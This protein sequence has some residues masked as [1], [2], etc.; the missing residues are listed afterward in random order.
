MFKQPHS[1][2][3]GK[4]S[5]ALYFTHR[6]KESL[7]GIFSRPLTI[8]EA[9]MGYGKTV[10]VRE[11]LRATPAR[12]LWVSV[13]N[14]AREDFW[15]NF[16]REILHHFPHYADLAESLLRLG[17][18][19]D[20][21]QLAAARELMLHLD[22]DRPAV[23]VIDDCHL[24]GDP[25]TQGFAALCELLAQDEIDNL[26]MVLVNREAY[27]G[28]HELPHLRGLAGFATKD[29]FTLT[30]GE[31]Q[32]YYARC[33]EHLP[34][35]H[36]RRL[37]QSTGGWISALYLH[38]LRYSKHGVLARP[39]GIAAL[40]EKEIYAP[41]PVAVK[42]LLFA[43]CP[44]DAFTTEQADFLY[45][46]STAGH[47]ETLRGKN[48]F[49]TFDA[50]SGTFVMHSI[51]KQ[52]LAELFARLPEERR[53]AIHRACG[54][55]FIQ[56]G[57]IASGME[58]YYAAKD[59]EK[60]L[61]ALESDMSRNLVTEKAAF[62]TEMFKACPEEI[63]ERHLPAAFKY[64]IAAFSA[65]DFPAFGAQ[66][67]W[68]AKRCAALPEPQPSVLNDARMWRG[69][70]EFLYSLAAYNDIKAMSAHHRR[71]NALLGRPTRL[72]GARGSPWTLGSPSVL[73]MFYRQS[74]KLKD[75]RK[76]MKECLPH[77]YQ[78]A[79]HHGAGGEWLLE[80]ES[81]YNAGD[82]T[83]AAVAAHKAEA[84]AGQHGQLSNVLCALFLHLRLALVSGDF[85]EARGL[86]AAMRE[87][88]KNSREYFL[89]HTVDMCEGWLYAA[90]GR[91]AEIPGWLARGTGGTGGTVG[92]GGTGGIGGT[93]ETGGNNRLY[94]FARGYYYIIHGRALLLA[95]EYAKALGLFEYLLEAGVFQKHLL[96]SV[97]AHIYAAAARQ[98][99]GRNRLA[100]E[101]LRKALDLALPDK[102]Y[103]P[104][105]ENADLLEPPLAALAENAVPRS[106]L[107]GILRLTKIW[108]KHKQRIL[109]G[110]FSAPALPLTKRELQL[111]RLALAGNKYKDIAQSLGLAPVTVKKTFAGIYRKLRIHDRDGL[112]QCLA[113]H[114]GSTIFSH[115]APSS[116]TK[117]RR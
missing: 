10:G 100:V 77:Y 34:E 43:L 105:V 108:K 79:S 22:F 78:L 117:A 64:A 114:E 5:G 113:G 83:S 111:A 27:S 13:K 58:A 96:F 81:L 69:E 51:F 90:L 35:K 44:L 82:F 45:K 17:Y 9:P 46:K 94:A 26:H 32:E 38:L 53:R 116:G 1:R 104:F 12:T 72:F 97:H 91:S 93:G 24:L 7:A 16:C 25:P 39:S 107:A 4:D 55:W 49:I 70:L 71:A 99:L 87:R 66:L 18:P 14:T 50:A 41:L 29:D 60:A 37:H 61:S 47:L 15:R 31:I 76:Q 62:F 74:G 106:G 36:A 112:R 59:F 102:V 28:G 109:A 63:L 89:L 19:Y 110:H 40:L 73:F 75:E 2:H 57:E 80:A 42:D 21:V 23:L 68:L 88:V 84:M 6:L 54:D 20:S 101:T 85:P 86:V 98:G 52:Y 92:T 3:S 67:G 95:G 103:M 30:P 115:D 48:A 65:A 11:F 33:G 56:Q 8:V